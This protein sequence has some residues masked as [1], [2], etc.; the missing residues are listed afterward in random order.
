MGKK[1]KVKSKYIKW[2][3]A[4]VSLHAGTYVCPLVPAGIMI[5]INWH[6]WFNSSNQWS[7]GLGFGSLL[8]SALITIIGVAKRDEVIN[9][10]VSSLFYLAA[11]MACW[12]I[13]LMFLASIAN[14]FGYM[15]LYTAMGLI[16]GATCDQINRMKVNK[17]V[18]LYQG[19]FNDSNMDKLAIKKEKIL[20]EIEEEKRRAI[21]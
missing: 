20:K 18:A 1:N 21:E 16:G 15:L 8:L 2:K 3:V 7:I 9:K 6:K 11:V 17:E 5:G 13:S 14:Q 4:K 10:N 12:A 19:A